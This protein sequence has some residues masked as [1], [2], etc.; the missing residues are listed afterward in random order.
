M[1][2]EGGRTAT[3]GEGFK[4]HLHETAFYSKG[5]WKLFAD[6]KQGSDVL[7]LDFNR[8]LW[9]LGCITGLYL[10][11]PNNI[12]CSRSPVKHPQ[13]GKNTHRAMGYNPLICQKP[14]RHL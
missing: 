5:N 7:S 12:S 9:L 1:R 4:D 13:K 6:N 11:F 3:H 8:V 2:P 10:F 14:E